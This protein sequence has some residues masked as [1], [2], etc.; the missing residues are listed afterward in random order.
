MIRVEVPELATPRLRM[1]LPM[2][3][4]L[5]A[6]A[7][8]RGSERSRFVGGP[9]TRAEAFSQLCAVVGHWHLRGYGRWIVTDRATGAPLGLVGLHHPDDWPECEI[10]WS[11]FE[12]AEGRGIAEE[13]ARAT[14]DYAYGTLGWT[15][16]ISMIAPDNTRSL[17]LARRLG[18]AHESDYEHP[19]FGQAQIWR[20]PAPAETEA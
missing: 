2:L 16:V 9:N 8:F 20:H 3:S 15:T 1:R 18:A 7:A 5:E 13:A 10:G 6:L 14:R 19:V 4:D 12:G 17:A 11:L